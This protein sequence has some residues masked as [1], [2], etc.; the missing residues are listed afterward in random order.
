MGLEWLQ[1]SKLR[2]KV[3]S[4]SSMSFSGSNEKRETR[5]LIVFGAFTFMYT[6]LTKEST[7]P[8]KNQ[9]TRAKE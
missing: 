1:L 3:S 4:S 5:E 2:R 6:I 8:E 7:H 9:S